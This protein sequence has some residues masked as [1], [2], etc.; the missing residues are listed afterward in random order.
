MFLRVSTFV[1]FVL[2][3]VGFS[4]SIVPAEGASGLNAALDD[5]EEE[6]E[7]K[8]KRMHEEELNVKK[9]ERLRRQRQEEEG[10]EESKQRSGMDELLG[11][12][13]Y[14]SLPDGMQLAGILSHRRTME[15]AMPSRSR[16]PRMRPMR[17]WHDSPP[18]SGQT[19]PEPPRR[20]SSGRTSNVKR[21]P[22]T[23][24]SG[25]RDMMRACN[26]HFFI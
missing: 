7:R 5:G 9:R 2:V 26:M 1:V 11:D 15:P 14:D 19:Q 21:G 6:E 25:L 12:S 4:A 23:R 22:S 24:L 16:G 3:H 20:I 10:E 8:R 18:I 17:A 13:T